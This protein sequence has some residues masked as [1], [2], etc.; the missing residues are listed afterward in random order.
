LASSSGSTRAERDAARR[1]R[2][3][4]ESRGGRARERQA[5]PGRVSADERPPPIWAPFPLTELVTLAGIV[6]MAWGLLGGGTA[7]NRRLTAGLAIAS[8]AGLELA[9]REHVTG[10]RSHSALL[11]GATAILVMVVAGLGLR[12]NPLGLVLLAGLVAFAGAFWGLRR[13]FQSRSGG[14]S[15]R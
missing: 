7:G 8:L 12:L 13:L 15:F 4:A 3:Q 14:L 11:A 1:Q 2:A 6:L 5:R 10:F 9:V